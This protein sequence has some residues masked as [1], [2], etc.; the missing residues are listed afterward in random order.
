MLQ[1]LYIHSDIKSRLNSGENPWNALQNSAFLSP[2]Y[3]S[4][5]LRSIWNYNFTHV[6]CIWA[7]KW[8]H[9]PRTPAR[10]CWEWNAEGSVST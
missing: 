5:E 2:T 3:K 10:G 8:I 9:Q 7:C 1:Y 4:N 6:T